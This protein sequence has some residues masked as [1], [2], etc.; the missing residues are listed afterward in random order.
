MC[1]KF[2]GEML[3]YVAVYS[4][5]EGKRYPRTFLYVVIPTMNALAVH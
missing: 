1:C 2:V 5:S 3:R 4:L